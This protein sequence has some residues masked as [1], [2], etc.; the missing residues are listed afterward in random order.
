[1]DLFARCKKYTRLSTDTKRDFPYVALSYINVT[2]CTYVAMLIG[3]LLTFDNSSD[4]KYLQ[5]WLLLS[6]LMSTMINAPTLWT[7][8]KTTEA[9][10]VIYEMKLFH[11]MYFSNMLLNYVVFLDNQMIT[12]FVFV[13]NL[14]HCCVIFMIFVELFILFGNTMGTY[15]DYQYV[16]SC[17]IVV[18]FVS[19]MS[20]TI[21]MGLQCLKTKLIENGFMFNV[22]VCALYIVVAI[23]W[24]LKNSYYVSNLQNIKVIPFSDNDPPPIFSN[25]VMDEIKK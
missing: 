8:L 13:N 12:N 3:Y 23:I 16:K 6:F 9:H 10:E 20:V 14:I 2:L 17:Y 7:I 19:T 18:L 21:V 1:M 15:T 4:L 22:L 24:S 5:Y 11:A 25:I